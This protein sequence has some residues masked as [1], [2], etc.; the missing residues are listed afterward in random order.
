[1]SLVR[2]LSPAVTETGR[3]RIRLAADHV[4]TNGPLQ[5]P[6]Y[7]LAVTPLPLPAIIDRI[8]FSLPHSI[9]NYASLN[10]SGPER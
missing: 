1:M 6:K 2:T 10:A 8:P 5:E 4:V 9:R 7:N 3:D